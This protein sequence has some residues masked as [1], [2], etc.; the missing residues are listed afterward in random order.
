MPVFELEI[1]VSLGYTGI[2][3]VGGCG[4]TPMDIM[5]KEYVKA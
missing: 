3:T 1:A 5:A 4:S 2:W